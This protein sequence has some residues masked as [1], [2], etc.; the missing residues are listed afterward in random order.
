MKIK[1]ADK[2]TEIATDRSLF[3]R[4]M[5]VT[6]SKRD[7]DLREIFRRYEL[8]AVPRLFFTNDGIMHQFQMKSK[9][10]HI[11]QSLA[12]NEERLLPPS[13]STIGLLQ[14]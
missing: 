10:I 13:T 5:M 4:L 11:V 1:L 14:S 6:R 9:L 7:L 2:V 12:A 8:C 3:A